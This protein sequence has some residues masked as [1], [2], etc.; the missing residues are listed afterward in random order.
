MRARGSLLPEVAVQAAYEWN[1][2]R[3]GRPVS[4]WVAGASVRLNVFS[5]GATLARMREAA[6]AAER[7]RAERDRIARAIE[8]EVLTAVEQLAAARSRESLGRRTVL[9][10]R[11]SQ[12]IIRNRFEAGMTPTSDVLR[13]AMAVL[14]AESQQVGAI[15]DVMVGEAALTRALGDEEVH[16]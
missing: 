10:A 1:D 9:Q 12:R 7:A 4:S 8:V 2:G 15:V 11:E 6:H 16:R 13:A 3:R 14:D 5:G